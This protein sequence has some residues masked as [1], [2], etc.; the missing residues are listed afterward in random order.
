MTST[1][2]PP[3][4]EPRP[5]SRRGERRATNR[6]NRDS[7]ALARDAHLAGRRPG[8]VPHLLGRH[9]TPCEISTTRAHPR[10]LLRSSTLIPPPSRYGSPP[11]AP[12]SRSSQ[13]RLPRSWPT[14][15]ARTAARSCDD[16]QTPSAGSGFTARSSWSSNPPLTSAYALRG[17]FQGRRRPLCV[18]ACRGRG[19]RN[20]RTDTDGEGRSGARIACRSDMPTVLR[21]RLP[22]DLPIQAAGSLA[23]QVVEPTA[24]RH[25]ALTQP[26]PRLLLLRSLRS[27][28]RGRCTR[29][30][31]LPGGG[32][33]AGW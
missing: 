5:R 6:A 23:P 19:R 31:A 10:I 13:R 9:R 18:R 27:S 16:A 4:P 29:R 33:K 15:A 22:A 8:P 7:A 1:R 28:A 11:W 20:A 26:L 21:H 32:A 17:E 12:T 30:S 25:P 3:G 24:E 14:S 2:W